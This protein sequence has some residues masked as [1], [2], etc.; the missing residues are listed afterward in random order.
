M[1]MMTLCAEPLA[2]TALPPGLGPRDHR[3]SACTSLRQCL[4]QQGVTL[5]ELLVVI[6]I[7][8][9]LAALLFPTFARARASARRTEC[10]SN[11]KQL[12][13][14][15]TM[16]S[17]DHDGLSPRASGWHRW[18]GDGTD[19]DEPGPAWEEQLFPYLHNEQIF[20]C[21]EH[22]SQVS[23]SYSLNTRF[24]WTHYSQKLI[25]MEMIENPSAYVLL[26]DCSAKELFAPPLGTARFPWD[27]CDKDNMTY[28]CLKYEDT[29]HGNGSNVLF[30]DGHAKFCTGYSQDA[31]TFDP[32]GMSDWR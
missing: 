17:D 1:M 19:G 12:G 2:D 6:A 10:M 32:F 9:I 15:I 18:E 29:A 13:I 30:A 25:M 3:A 7:I 28:R 31:M 22:P 8:G 23:F 21:P 20:R 14:A 11:L 16:Y 24:W 4:Q 26:S 5:I 27:T